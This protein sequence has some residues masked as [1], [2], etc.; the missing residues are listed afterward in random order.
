MDRTRTLAKKLDEAQRRGRAVTLTQ[1]QAAEL[2]DVSAR[3]DRADRLLREP[4]PA[5]KRPAWVRWIRERN[6]YV[7][8]T[9]TR[10]SLVD[11]LS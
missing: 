4:D 9:T 11:L 1:Q 6:R 2:L 7:E 3:F 10:V 8:E 5:W